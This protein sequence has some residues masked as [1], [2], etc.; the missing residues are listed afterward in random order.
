MKDL[1][2]AAR[3]QL[4]AIE[5][6]RAAARALPAEQRSKIEGAWNECRALGSRSA[7]ARNPDKRKRLARAAF[8]AFERVVREAQTARLAPDLVSAGVAALGRLKAAHDL[9]F[10]PPPPVV[11]REPRAPTVRARYRR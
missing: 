9:A 7:R 10:P 4:Q 1:H 2:A 8:A 5:P 3:D 11:A 6:I